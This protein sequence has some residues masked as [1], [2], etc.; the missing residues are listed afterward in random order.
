LLLGGHRSSIAGYQYD[1]AIL[2]YPCAS[3]RSGGFFTSS[4]VIDEL[5]EH[6]G[7]VAVVQQLVDDLAEGLQLGAGQVAAGQDQARVAT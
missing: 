1:G 5:A 4:Q 3:H 6:Q 2:P 7:L